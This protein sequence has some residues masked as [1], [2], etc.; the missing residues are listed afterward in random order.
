V[1]DGTLTLLACRLDRT[2]T[3]RLLRQVMADHPLPA[4]TASSITARVS[5]HIPHAEHKL[6]WAEAL[7]FYWLAQALLNTLQAAPPNEPGWNSFTGIRYR[8]ML[9]SSRTFTRMGE[10]VDTANGSTSS[11]NGHG[12]VNGPSMGDLSGLFSDSPAAW[13]NLAF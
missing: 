13:D 5:H 12:N 10:G 7:P 3:T 4:G 6:T 9:K 1:K 8:D 11:T 2:Q